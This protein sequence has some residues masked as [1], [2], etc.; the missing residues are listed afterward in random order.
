MNAKEHHILKPQLFKDKSKP[1]T[2]RTKDTQG[3]KFQKSTCVGKMYETK[4]ITYCIKPEMLI[5]HII[6]YT[7]F[8]SEDQ[9]R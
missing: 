1:S 2:N 9:S 3:S 4:L 7:A 6:N 5:F 8:I